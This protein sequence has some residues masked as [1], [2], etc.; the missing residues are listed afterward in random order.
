MRFLIT[1]GPTREPLDPVRFLSNRSTGRMGYA[2]AEAVLAAGHECLLVS[3][4]VNLP[5]PEGAEAVPVETAEEMYLAVE[6]N[7]PGVEVAFFVAAVADYR[8]RVQVA[9][10]LKKAGGEGLVLELERTRDILGSARSVM[11]F[12]GVLVG[13][14]AET[15][16]LRHNARGKMERKGCN[17]LA[18]NDVSKAGVGFGSSRNEILLLHADGK[19]EALPEASKGELGEILVA[20]ALA[21][22]E[23][24]A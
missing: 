3:G 1:A 7:I 23:A 19:E 11:K 16:N 5:V 18:A 21:V 17:L 24:S 4:P 6:R 22:A 8:P 10:K 2:I 9:Q 15:E 13:F 12:T 14:A 20:R